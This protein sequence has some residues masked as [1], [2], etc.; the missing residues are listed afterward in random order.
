MYVKFLLPWII[1]EWMKR[2]TLLLLSEWLKWLPLI[3]IKY[4]TPRENERNQYIPN[5]TNNLRILRISPIIITNR[6]ITI[7]MIFFDRIFVEFESNFICLLESDQIIYNFKW[8]K[9]WWMQFIIKVRKCGIIFSKLCNNVS[10][11]SMKKYIFF[12]Y[13]T[14]LELDE[15]LHELLTMLIEIDTSNYSTACGWAEK[16]LI[17]FCVRFYR[18]DNTI[19]IKK[20]VLSA[21]NPKCILL[22]LYGFYVCAFTVEIRDCGQQ[23][24]KKINNSIKENH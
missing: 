15:S 10:G 5:F 7:Y 13:D 4:L 19:F 11:E 23:R 2:V 14:I 12:V 8:K 20:L 17:K 22:Y 6:N 24:N 16:I 9:K 3:D 18:K 1:S 21:A